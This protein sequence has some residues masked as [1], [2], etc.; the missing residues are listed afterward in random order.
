MQRPFPSNQLMRTV[1]SMADRDVLNE[2]LDLELMSSVYVRNGAGW[3]LAL[4]QQTPVP[5]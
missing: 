1:V 2:L 3:N 5:D 4:Y